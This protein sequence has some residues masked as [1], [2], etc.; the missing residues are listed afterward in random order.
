MINLTN[1]IAL[2]RHHR[3]MVTE[4]CLPTC[5]C[6]RVEEIIK[7]ETEPKPKP[8]VVELVTRRKQITDKL[9]KHAGELDK[10]W[11]GDKP[12]D[13]I[14]GQENDVQDGGPPNITAM[15]ATITAVSAEDSVLRD[16]NIVYLFGKGE[17]EQ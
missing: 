5:F 11:Y 1:L 15:Q 7:E 2:F 9:C 6:H 3:K 12:D 10:K 13:Y 8:K 14:S 16:G 4:P 17:E